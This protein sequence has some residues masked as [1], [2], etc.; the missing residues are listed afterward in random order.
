MIIR[1]GVEIFRN[2]SS[3]FEHCSKNLPGIRS[4]F[5]ICDATVTE[6]PRTLSIPQSLRLAQQRYK[7]SVIRVAS[8]LRALVNK[9]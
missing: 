3:F 1:I 4:M 5:R 2:T 6:R 7:Q 9:F 8:G